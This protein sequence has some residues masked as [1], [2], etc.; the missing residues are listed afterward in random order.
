MIRSFWLLFSSE[1][2]IFSHDHLTLGGRAWTGRNVIIN[3]LFQLGLGSCKIP[4]CRRKAGWGVIL[5]FSHT[6]PAGFSTSVW[7]GMPVKLSPGQI[8]LGT[9]CAILSLLRVSPAFSSTE[10]GG[11]DV[12]IWP[13]RSVTPTGTWLSSTTCFS[14]LFIHLKFIF[15]HKPLLMFMGCCSASVD[16]KPLAEQG[17][18]AGRDTFLATFEL[19]F[20]PRDICFSLPGEIFHAGSH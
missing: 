2:Q 14:D 9:P 18:F 4:F 5:N 6:G 12:I 16:P 17:G 10:I 19:F 11:T 15:Q 3:E 7:F 8:P 20:S 13:L 1:N